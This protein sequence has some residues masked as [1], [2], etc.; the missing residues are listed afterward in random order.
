MVEEFTIER[1]EAHRFNKKKKDMEF[2]IKWDGYPAEEN[3]WE[4][5]SNL[6]EDGMG[7]VIAAFLADVAAAA[8]AQAEAE[9][10]KNKKKGKKKKKTPAKKRSKTPPPAAEKKT[11]KKKQQKEKTPRAKTPARGKTAGKA[12]TAKP[13][14]ALKKNKRGSA[15]K[16]SAS[17]DKTPTR[18]ASRQSSR[19]AQ[20][21]DPPVEE[22]ADDD[23]DDDDVD[24]VV[25]DENDD[26]ADDDTS[27]S[28]SSSSSG[29]AGAANALSYASDASFPTAYIFWSGAFVASVCLYI[30][31]SVMLR[32][33]IPC[34]P[35]TP[36]SRDCAAEEAQLRRVLSSVQ[37][38]AGVLPTVIAGMSLYALEEKVHSPL[39]RYVIAA[40][41]WLAAGQVATAIGD[42]QA[43]DGQVTPVARNVALAAAAAGQTF[44]VVAF[45]SRQAEL[46]ASPPWTPARALPF[47]LLMWFV[48]SEQLKPQGALHQALRDKDD[49]PL[50]SVLMLVLISTTCLAGW[51]AASRVG[52]GGVGWRSRRATKQLLAV[53]AALSTVLGMMVEFQGTRVLSAGFLDDEFARAIYS[54]VATWI[55]VGLYTASAWM[56]CADA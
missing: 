6:E 29:G 19:R 24:A 41:V 33:V 12:T 34:M 9:E 44:L 2:L 11:K 27:S 39:A 47:A 38:V 5:K 8:A 54:R 7:D 10:G 51:R 46:A 30:L 32:G 21:S 42:A 28:S 31:A 25:D 49:D 43:D 23:E 16:A 1:I 52:Y 13:K 40:C 14:S 4:T 22:G 18:S 50:R 45:G 36:A 35:D 37:T 55:G 53:V 17:R 20:F 48:F 26:F 3:T 56:H 15:K